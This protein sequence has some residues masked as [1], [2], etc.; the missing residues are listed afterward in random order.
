[1]DSEKPDTDILNSL[2]GDDTDA[3]VKHKATKASKK[4]QKQ[5]DTFDSSYDSDDSVNDGIEI[6]NFKKRKAQKLLDNDDEAKKENGKVEIVPQQR[7]NLS[8]YELAL[9]DLMVNS[10]KKKFELIDDSYHRYT[11]IYDKA[12]ASQSPN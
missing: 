12:Y 9:G 1:L 5:P 10:K 6:Q 3:V 7:I 8:S 11:I 2:A 4:S